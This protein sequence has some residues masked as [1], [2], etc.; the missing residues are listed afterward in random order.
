MTSMPRCAGGLK[1]SATSIAVYTQAA[2]QGTP[3]ILRPDRVDG[4]SGFFA[5]DA[6]Y[7]ASLT[8][9]IVMWDTQDY[10][11][12]TGVTCEKLCR[13]TAASV[14]ACRCPIVTDR[15]VPWARPA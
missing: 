7:A 10:P 1:S 4:R 9:L 6:T 12:G 8:S 14:S 15:T 11:G 13:C 2:Y 3:L 5:L